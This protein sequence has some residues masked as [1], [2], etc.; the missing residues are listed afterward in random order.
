[1]QHILYGVMVFL[2]YGVMDSLLYEY[3]ENDGYSMWDGDGLVMGFVLYMSR[4]YI[5]YP[6]SSTIER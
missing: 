6:P 5:I 2:Q 1:M 4:I 3:Q